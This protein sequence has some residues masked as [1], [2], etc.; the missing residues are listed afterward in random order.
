MENQRKKII[1]NEIL[2]WK[3]NKLL[4][5]QYCNFLMTLYS[6][7]EEVEL[8]TDVGPN[9]ALKAKEQQKRRTMYVLFAVL[10]AVLLSV[11]FFV[12]KFSGV[13]IGIIGIVGI[14]LMISAFILAKKNKLMA[15]ILQVIAALLV[16]GVSVKFGNAYFEQN[17]LVLYLLLIANCL[18]WLVSG[19]TMKLLYFTLS[20]ILGLMVLIVYKLFM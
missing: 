15:L 18:L 16:F 13:I 11:P 9:K 6:E 5:D 7:G 1:I 12:S 8:N 2:F 3:K 17:N 19:L 4:P 10:A 14:S 20:G